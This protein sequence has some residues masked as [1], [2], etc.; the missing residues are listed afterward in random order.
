MSA[1]SKKSMPFEKYRPYETVTLPDR[2]W[3]DTVVSR[4]P[5]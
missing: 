3:P 4:A 1:Q 2:T 5:I